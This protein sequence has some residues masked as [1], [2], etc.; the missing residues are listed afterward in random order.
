MKNIMIATDGSESAEQALEVAIELAREL[1]ASLQVVA[2]RPTI[3]G[4]PHRSQSCRPR[5]R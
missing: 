4:G 1:G 2:V 3:A 5:S